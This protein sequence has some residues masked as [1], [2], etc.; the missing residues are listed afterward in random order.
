MF[1]CRDFILRG[2]VVELAV[3]VVLGTAFTNL[4]SAVTSVSVLTRANVAPQHIVNIQQADT[5]LAC[6]KHAWQHKWHLGHVS[7]PIAPT[8]G[9][10]MRPDCCDASSGVLSQ[11]ST[12]IKEMAQRYSHFNLFVHGAACRTGSLR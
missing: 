5:Q 2:T 1:A 9:H 3:A 11:T 7:Y 12:F 6:R 8:A 10:M 4:I